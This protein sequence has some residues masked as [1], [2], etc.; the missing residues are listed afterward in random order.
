MINDTF[1]VSITTFVYFFSA[2]VFLISY[3]FKK[4]SAEKIALVSTVAGMAIHTAALICRWIHSYQMGIGHAP[5]SNF[6]ESMVFFSW[7]L[8]F[9]Y[10]VTRK[11]DTNNL[12]GI[13][14]TFFS[15][16]IL[17][18]TTLSPNVDCQIQPLIPA[19]QSNWLTSHVIT[20]FFAYACFAIAFGLSILYLLK[21]TKSKKGIIALLP[22]AAVL[23][24]ATYN[25]I[26]LGFVLL[27]LGIITGAAW[28]EN[29]WGRYWGWDPKETWS[30]ITWLIYGAF[31]HARITKGWKGIR[32]SLVSILGF[33]AVIF[34]YLGVNYILSGLHSYL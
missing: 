29:A 30:L 14:A 10:L 21:R 28:A 24:E 25:M 16:L 15:F 4:K 8:V 5:L 20:C 22:D 27:T 13:L 11:Q 1:L 3:I 17:A 31:L 7:S 33:T 12:G 34:T 23:D 18:Y 9:I 19:L 32:M 6:Y 2:F 26:S